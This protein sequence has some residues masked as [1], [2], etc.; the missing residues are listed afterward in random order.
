MV[1][2]EERH[3]RRDVLSGKKD[4]WL[5]RDGEAERLVNEFAAD[6]AAFIQVRADGASAQ[7]AQ[8]VVCWRACAARVLQ[9][10]RPA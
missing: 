10:D 7:A 8:R 2:C 3:L 9:V 1:C 4:A 5:L 6:E